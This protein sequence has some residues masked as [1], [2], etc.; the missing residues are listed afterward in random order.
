MNSSLIHRGPD[1]EGYFLDRNIGLAVRR[2]SIIDLD[3]GHQPIHNEDQTIWTVCNGEIYNYIELRDSLRKKGHHFYTGSDVEVLVHLYEEHGDD[4]FDRL[5]GMFAFAL[6]DAPRKKLILA[7]DHVGVKPLFYYLDDQ[8][9]V[10]G[11]EIKAVH[12]CLP[13]SEIDVEALSHYLSFLCVTT[14]H[15]I[16]KDVKRLEPGHCLVVDPSGPR[17]RKYWEFRFNFDHQSNETETLERLESVFRNCIRRQLRSDVPLGALLSG[18]LDS[19]MLVQFMGEQMSEPVKTFTIGFKEKSFDERPQARTAA[20][21]LN[22]DHYEIAMD[23]RVGDMIE[24]LLQYFD[25]PYADYGAIP[26]FL[27][28]GLARSHVKVVLTG[29]GGDEFFGGYQT[30]LAPTVKDLYTR[31]PA[32][33]RRRVVEPLVR[34][35]PT[36]YNRITFDFM[37]KRFISGADLPYDE[38][39]YHWKAVFNPREQRQLLHPDLAEQTDFD[40]SLALYRSLFERT[41][42]IDTKNRLMHIDI[43]V[44]L[45]DIVLAK[46]DLMSMAHGLEARVPFCDREF[47]EFSA[48]IPGPMKTRLFKTKHLFRKLAQKKLPRE[49]YAQKK[50]GFSPPMAHWLCHELKDLTRDALSEKNLK[51]VGLF[52]PNYVQRLIDQHL[53]QKVD[54]NRKIWAL[55]VFMVWWQKFYRP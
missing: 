50:K 31:M 10:F 49:I 26:L 32:A 39:H 23:G 25:E 17:I 13:H 27:V 12:R 28:S 33:L 19:S 16:Y 34:S 1:D 5:N 41:P 29:D 55:L 43:L 6:W 18:G 52:D 20:R 42:G 7:R 14:P 9:L 24:T 35:L 22:T 44:F 2:L 36:S 8:R 45:R 3:H 38:G 47:V 11:S 4:L 37:A 51:D 48:T 21:A 30:Y 53:S 15:T 40:V 54:H 46:A